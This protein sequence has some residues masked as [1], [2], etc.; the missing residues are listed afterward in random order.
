M[1]VPKS[2]EEMIKNLIGLVYMSFKYM[3]YEELKKTYNE[4]FEKI[5]KKLEHDLVYGKEE[6]END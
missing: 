6:N 3:S 2:R 1:D 5:S 4:T